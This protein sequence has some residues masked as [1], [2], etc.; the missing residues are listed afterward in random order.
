MQMSTQN[1]PIKQ[2]S[3]RWPNQEPNTLYK[4]TKQTLWSVKITKR[5]LT[6]FGLVCR[7][8]ETTPF[9]IASRE[10]LKPSK[11]P[12]GRPRTY[13]QVIKTQLKEKHEDAMMEA[14]DREKWRAVL[15]DPS[16]LGDKGQQ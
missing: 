7:L 3:R 16:F 8:P 6:F 10:D 11:K 9:K 5:R 4:E 1:H 12:R 14:K 2:K 15:Q 13:L